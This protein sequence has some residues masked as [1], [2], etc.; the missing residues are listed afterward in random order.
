MDEFQT[1]PTQDEH[2]PVLTSEQDALRW[3]RQV[4][5]TAYHN[6]NDVD[7]ENAWVAVVR[8][9]S[10]HGKVGKLILAFG[11]SVHEA[12]CAAEA[13]WTALWSSLSVKH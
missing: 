2:R 4:G 7:G 1:A 11:E 12:A 8:T 6:R 13:E 5:G 9:P 3:L 10:A